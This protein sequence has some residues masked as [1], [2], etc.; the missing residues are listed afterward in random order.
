[1]RGRRTHA[2]EIAGSGDDSAAEMVMPD[3]IGDGAPGER[4]AGIA[5]P[6]GKGRAALALIVRPGELEAVLQGGNA[7]ERAGCGRLARFANVAAAEDVNG[8]AALRRP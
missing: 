8:P 5:N 7:G 2:A 3:T 1:M 4:I 6:S